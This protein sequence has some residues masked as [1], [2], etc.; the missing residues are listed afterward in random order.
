MITYVTEFYCDDY[1]EIRVYTEPGGLDYV[2]QNQERIEK[3]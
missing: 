3:E 2:Y 1:V